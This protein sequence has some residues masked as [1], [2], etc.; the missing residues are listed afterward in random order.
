[1]MMMMMMDKENDAHECY[2]KDEDECGD[3]D[4]FVKQVHHVIRSSK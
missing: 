4:T 2:N 3:E 1:M